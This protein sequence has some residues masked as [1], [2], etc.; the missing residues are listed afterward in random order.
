MSSNKV[1]RSL[2]RSLIKSARH[3]SPPSPSFAVFASLLTRTG[4]TVDWDELCYNLDK[5][6]KA[7]HTA[8]GSEDGRPTKDRQTN[9]P[10]SWARDLSRSYSQLRTDYETRRSRLERVQ[11]LDH[12]EEEEE[13]WEDDDGDIIPFLHSNAQHARERYRVSALLDHA[14][15]SRLHTSLTPLLH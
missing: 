6:R 11:G 3:F 4:E 8:G 7:R 15:V 10:M 9:M 1:T 12:V 14:R 5:L 13:E 2:Y